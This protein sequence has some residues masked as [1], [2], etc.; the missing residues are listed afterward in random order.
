MFGAKFVLAYKLLIH[1]YRLSSAL[2]LLC[3]DVDK[4]ISSSLL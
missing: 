3:T 1:H 2:I 4:D